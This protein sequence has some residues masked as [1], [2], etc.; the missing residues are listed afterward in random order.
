MMQSLGTALEVTLVPVYQFFD[1]RRKVGELVGPTPQELLDM[2]HLAQHEEF[3]AR[4]FEDG[5]QH[6]MVSAAE[7]D[8][9]VDESPE[10]EHDEVMQQH[11]ATI[12]T[13]IVTKL[14]RPTPPLKPLLSDAD[15]ACLLDL[16]DDDG[17]LWTA[18]FCFAGENI[19]SFDHLSCA[20]R[21]ADG[22]VSELH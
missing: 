21:S 7:Q 6:N 19:R 10:S 3:V 15:A 13:E 20:R 2:L 9:N 17:V 12:L 11:R 22:S 1:Q 14:A 8:E 4:L 18:F 5:A 16:I